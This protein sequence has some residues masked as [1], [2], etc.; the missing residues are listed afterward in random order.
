M[1]VP[2]APPPTFAATFRS[3]LRRDVLAIC[4]LIFMADLV[5]GMLSS[6]FSL[7]AQSL[8]ATFAVIGALSSVVGITQMFIS[9]PIGLASDRSGRKRVLVLGMAVMGIATALFAA[10][11]DVLWL[12]AG[13]ILLGVAFVSTFQI[14][15]AAL[16][17]VVTPAERGLAYGMYTTTMGVGFALGP[18]VAT[19]ITAQAGMPAAYA[20]ASLVS[21]AGAL[22][23]WRLLPEPQRPSEIGT[24]RAPVSMWDAMRAMLANPH[25]VAG[26]LANLLI[27]T[28]FNGAVSNFFPVYV[29]EMGS[30]QAAVNTMFSARAVGSTCARFPS[31]ALTTRIAPRRMIMAALF[32][33][34]GAVG[35]MSIGADPWLLGL[36]LV[37]EGVAFGMHLPSGQAFCAEQST[38]ATR[39]QV[40]GGY[41]MTGSLGSALAP[42]VMGLV[43]EWWGVRAV[44]PFTA[45]L[46]VGG[47]VLIFVLFRRPAPNA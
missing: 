13:R 24:L 47:L 25:L 10:A 21:V 28:I 22:I 1:T 43:A 20:L 14:G 19:L 27:N 9:V 38:A 6:T 40:V 12:F 33:A 8:G 17:D 41:S 42:L 5:A 44:F 3:L 15:V 32:I 11:P 26:S 45:A 31:G 7:Y 16:G 39:G 30:T 18:Q 34:L 23:G 46:I 36:L 35:L 37:A 29:A 4:Y 2:T